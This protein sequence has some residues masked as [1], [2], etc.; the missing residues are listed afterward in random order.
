MPDTYVILLPLIALHHVVHVADDVPDLVVQFLGGVPQL[1]SSHGAHVRHGTHPSF[2]RRLLFPLKVLLGFLGSFLFY[3]LV[4]SNKT[5]S[6][7]NRNITNKK[8][9]QQPTNIEQSPE[10]EQ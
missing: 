8:E 6:Y 1:V 7:N 9:N 5:C 2:Q 10:I 4:K 3:L